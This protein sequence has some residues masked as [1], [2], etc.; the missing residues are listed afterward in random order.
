MRQIKAY[1]M[2]S[3]TDTF[4]KGA[5]AFRNMRDYAEEQRN[6]S[7]HRANERAKTINDDVVDEVDEAVD[8]L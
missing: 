2:T 1:A 7:I 8:G 5:S 6:G 3:D 4:R